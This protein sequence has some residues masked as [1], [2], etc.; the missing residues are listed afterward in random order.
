[1]S[2]HPNARRSLA[3][4]LG[5]MLS[6]LHVDGHA[7]APK[8]GITVVG[9]LSPT[10]SFSG[11]ALNAKG[12]VAGTLTE[13]GGLPVA[14]VWRPGA[15][16]HAIGYLVGFGG[17]SHAAALNDEGMVVGTSGPPGHSHA[18]AWTHENRM[19]DLGALLPDARATSAMSV[20]NAGEVVIEENVIAFHALAG[21][22]AWTWT[23]DQGLAEIVPTFAGASVFAK[24][25]NQLGQVTGYSGTPTGWEAMVWSRAAGMQTL[26][27][28]QGWYDGT[29]G[30]AI[31][32]AGQVVGYST[33]GCCVG[34]VSWTAQDGWSALGYLPNFLGYSDAFAV[35]GHGVVVGVS[36]KGPD[37]HDVAAIWFPG[38]PVVD[39]NNL[40][41]PADP[42]AGAVKLSNAVGINDAGQI[43]ANGT[44][45]SRA[46]A[47]V[48][49]P[50]Q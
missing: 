24:G 8:Y 22:H 28:P 23:A 48:L 32:D 35:N 26:G 29:A 6:A 37:A 40:V 5:A 11:A 36:G 14:A 12:Q 21:G 31:N 15:P 30:V 17:Q 41:D 38:H 2:I 19:T 10:Q 42:L 4:A 20:D 39:L 45:D 43:L 49:T 9:P 34:A 1:M 50:V 27:R 44:L 13:A 25:I 16:V 47:V 33:V 3:F 46:Q 18:F 7:A